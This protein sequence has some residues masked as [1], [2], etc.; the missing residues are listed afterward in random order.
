M[1]KTKFNQLTN[2]KIFFR[3]QKIICFNFNN[4]F[5]LYGFLYRVSWLAIRYYFTKLNV[6]LKKNL[7]I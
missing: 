5:Q 7:V 3:D 1:L 4:K 2:K 6:K